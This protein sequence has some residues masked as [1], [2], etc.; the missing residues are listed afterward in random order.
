MTR[1]PTPNAI[2]YIEFPSP[3]ANALQRSQ[4][5]FSAVFNWR[6]KSWGDDY[7]DTAGSGIGSGLNADAAHRPQ[8]ALAVVY[9]EDLAAAREQ[10]V[11]AGGAITRDI[12]S[13]PGGKRFHFREPGGIEL[14]VWSDK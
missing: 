12:F 10:V 14:A 11:A 4:D 1:V 5:F 6:Y 9:V 2:T 13:F 3:D 7:V 8:Q